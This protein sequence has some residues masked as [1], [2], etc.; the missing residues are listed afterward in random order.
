MHPRLGYFIGQNSAGKR[1]EVALCGNDSRT[2]YGE[3]GFDL[4]LTECQIKEILAAPKEGGYFK[5]KD[6][7]WLYAK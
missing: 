7:P 5:R 6:F 4:T 3:F 1:E 2:L